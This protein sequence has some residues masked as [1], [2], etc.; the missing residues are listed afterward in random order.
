MDILLLMIRSDNKKYWI[1][2]SI[3]I[4]DNMCDVIK[5]NGTWKAWRVVTVIWLG[6]TGSVA[7][8]LIMIIYKIIPKFVKRAHFS[9]HSSC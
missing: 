1:L 3:N 2:L 4:N 7:N 9:W 5:T 8:E 6:H